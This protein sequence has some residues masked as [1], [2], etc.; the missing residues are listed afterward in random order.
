MHAELAI[1]GNELGDEG[2]E[3]LATALLVGVP[4]MREACM[5][6]LCK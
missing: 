3:A 2:V 4:C 1:E 6:A 5:L